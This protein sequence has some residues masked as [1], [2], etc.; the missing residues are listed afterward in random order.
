METEFKTLIDGLIIDDLGNRVFE[1]RKVK[2]FIE[3]LIDWIIKHKENV[4]TSDELIEEI[5]RRAG[6]I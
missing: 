2:E 4:I 6:K 3:G 1:E 5:N